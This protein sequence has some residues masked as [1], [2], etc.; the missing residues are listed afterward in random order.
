MLTL[1]AVTFSYIFALPCC[2]PVM[3][4]SLHDS[5]APL[6]YAIALPRARSLEHPLSPPVPE[7]P[8]PCHMKSDAYPISSLSTCPHDAGGGGDGNRQSV[9]FLGWA[10]V[11][12]GRGPAQTGLDASVMRSFSSVLRFMGVCD[13]E[14]PHSQVWQRWYTGLWLTTPLHAPWASL[15]S[16]P[17]TPTLL[18]GLRLV[19]WFRRLSPTATYHRSFAEATW[20][21]RP[22][23]CMQAISGH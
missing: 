19:E 2:T 9:V 4:I 16:F 14:P 20:H 5:C 8:P 3:L 6:H 21:L 15:M 17:N 23:H 1:H 10:S 11:V 7:P 22:K 18:H 12:Y 13:V